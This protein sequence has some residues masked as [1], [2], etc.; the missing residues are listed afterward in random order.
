MVIIDNTIATRKATVIGF[1]I[2]VCKQDRTENLRLEL[3]NSYRRK[4]FTYMSFVDY[5][6]F[7]RPNNFW[8]R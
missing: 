4:T 3:C 2:L 7:T 6:V 5:F 1:L 8:K